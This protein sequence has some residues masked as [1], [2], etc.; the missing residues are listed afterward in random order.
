MPS[1]VP[2]ESTWASTTSHVNFNLVIVDR[3][4][5]STVHRSSIQLESIVVGSGVSLTSGSPL[6]PKS[7]RVENTTA[8]NK[9]EWSLE[10]LPLRTCIFK[11]MVI[12][13]M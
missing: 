4:A 7:K 6:Q 2:V 10:I 12:I 5:V 1:T 3:Q 9:M 11:G 13:A 8:I